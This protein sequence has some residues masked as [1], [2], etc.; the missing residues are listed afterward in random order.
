MKK[1][2]KTGCPLAQIATSPCNRSN[3]FLNIQSPADNVV[4]RTLLS[5]DAKK[6]FDSIDWAYLERFG[7]G[8]QYISWKS[9]EQAFK[10]F[11]TYAYISLPHVLAVA[12]R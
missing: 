11:Y 2:E 10:V 7:F 8:S 5:L 3:H 1:G 9:S 12:E 4:S 6:A